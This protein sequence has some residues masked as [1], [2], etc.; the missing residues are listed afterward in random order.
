MPW[1]RGYRGP[2]IINA[3]AIVKIQ[4]AVSQNDIDVTGGFDIL[5][6]DL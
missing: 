4:A 1:D 2:K 3:G 5:L 6:E